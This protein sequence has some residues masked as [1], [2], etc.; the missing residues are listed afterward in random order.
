MSAGRPLL[1]AA[2]LV[3]VFGG[4]RTAVRAVD[5]VDLE[6]R[7]GEIVLVMGPSGSGKTT[8]LTMIGGL[9]H[10]SEGSIE[11]DGIEV[12]RLGRRE[13]ARF[14]RRTVGFVF[15]TFNLLETLTAR[16][17]VEVALNVGGTVGRPAHLRATELLVAAGLE[18]R[19]EF[20]SRELSGG[21]K[22]RVSI[23]RALANRPR[24]L[25]ADEPTANLDSRHGRE[26][27][28]LLRSLAR[29]EGCAVVAVSHDERL[30]AIADRV[31][32]LEDGRIRPGDAA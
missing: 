22:Q 26:V 20:R 13:L 4:G 17:N 32:W 31:L 18:E 21:E 25:L 3:R 15:Q 9:L 7:A 8:L 2:G 28:E 30:R 24:L 12:T 10:P 5:G 14:R 1:A 19:L 11:I 6:V 16:E 27:M 23:A 29:E